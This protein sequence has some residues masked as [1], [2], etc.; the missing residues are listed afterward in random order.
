MNKQ[1]LELITILCNILVFFT[2][3]RNIESLEFKTFQDGR[4]FEVRKDAAVEMFTNDTFN[5]QMSQGVSDNASE[6]CTFN[7]HECGYSSTR[8][9]HMQWSW[10]DL[11]AKIENYHYKEL[12]GGV[13]FIKDILKNSE[14][15]LEVLLRTPKYFS[16][17]MHSF[18]CL[19]FYAY[20]NRFLENDNTM[21]PNYIRISQAPRKYNNYYKDF[22]LEADRWLEIKVDMSVSEDYQVEFATFSYYTRSIVVVDD[23][24]I[25]DGRCSDMKPITSPSTT[26]TS[27]FTTTSTPDPFT[28][29]LSTTENTP[30]LFT[31]TLS[32]TESTPDLFTNTLSTTESTLDLF[33][34]TLSTTESTSTI[35]SIDE[36]KTRKTMF[37]RE[38]QNTNPSFTT[39]GTSLGR[40]TT[41]KDSA[42]PS[43]ST[44]QLTSTS[45]QVTSNKIS[46]LSTTSAISTS[47][48]ENIGT[49]NITKD[50]KKEKPTTMAL[51]IEPATKHQ[52]LVFIFICFLGA[53]FFIV[54][55]G[56]ALSAITYKSTV[57]CFLMLAR[58]TKSLKIKSLQEDGRALEIRKD[59]A[60]DPQNTDRINN[61]LNLEGSVILFSFK[62]QS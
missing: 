30:D 14:T 11:S 52:M 38:D 6:L 36:E 55:V 9:G 54:L 44:F 17:R 31:S 23:V 60:V 27:E 8:H 22:K 34:S 24:R 40:L 4:T 18:K 26:T 61:Q 58:N 37:T 49:S 42:S 43:I 28:S 7:Q 29:T 48:I 32:T 57:F 3:V 56:V 1:A 15:A 62:E 12:Q 2:H 19:H 5:N 13:W 21:T 35:G 20:W 45:K 33:I 39:E 25:V 46:T 53:T 10:K 59:V 51:I 41:S 47:D 16:K 50:D